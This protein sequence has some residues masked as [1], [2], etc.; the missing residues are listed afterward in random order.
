MV[1]WLNARKLNLN[2]DHSTSFVLGDGGEGTT[3]DGGTFSVAEKS[4]G[5]SFTYTAA[6]PPPAR[7]ADGYEGFPVAFS[8]CFMLG[9]HA[10]SLHM[11]CQPKS[12]G[13]LCHEG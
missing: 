11:V 5:V 6:L 4:N 10:V 13:L 3:S 1:N 9:N 7:T 2:H 8:G 12:T